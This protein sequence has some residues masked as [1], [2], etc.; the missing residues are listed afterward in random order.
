MP[1][2]DVIKAVR[3]GCL[4]EVTDCIHFIKGPGMSDYDFNKSVKAVKKRIKDVWE[5]PEFKWKCCKVKFKFECVKDAANDADDKT[6]HPKRGRSTQEGL[7]PS[8]ST[9]NWFVGEIGQPGGA[10]L[11]LEPDVP[12]APHEV[13]HELGLRDKYHAV[14]AKGDPVPEQV[15]NKDGDLV[16]NPKFDH[17]KPEANYPLDGVMFDPPGNPIPQQVDID[18]ILAKLGVDCPDDCCE[19]KVI[20]KK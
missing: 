10:G 12:S 6:L 4:I 18:E 9:G 8:K 7:G 14:D 11:P 19:E 16:N 17:Y 2:Q 3:R 13:G 1:N 15:V 20:K 5:A